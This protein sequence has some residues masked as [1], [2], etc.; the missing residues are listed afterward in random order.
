[1]VNSLYNLAIDA[2]SNLANLYGSCINEMN[3]NMGMKATLKNVGAF[4]KN[5]AR[6]VNEQISSLSKNIKS[7]QVKYRKFVN[8]SKNGSATK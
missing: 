6:Q 7:E 4:I 8:Y 5:D 2:A 3:N 1:M